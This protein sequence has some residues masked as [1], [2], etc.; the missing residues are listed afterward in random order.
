MWKDD[1]LK[2]GGCLQ[3]K[4]RSRFVKRVNTHEGWRYH[5]WHDHDPISLWRT[6]AWMSQFP[7]SLCRFTR[8]C[9]KMICWRM[10]AVCS[11]SIDLVLSKESTPTKDEGT[12][13]DTTTIQF[14]FDTPPL[15]AWMSRFPR[16]FLDSHVDVERWSAEEWRLSAVKVKISFC[17]KSQHPRRMKV[18]QLTRPRS[19]FTL[20]H[21]RCLRGRQNSPVPS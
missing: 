6:P 18:P 14:H 19:N 16:P 9:G 8:W 21:P 10:E 20:T 17:Q 13:V 5:S 3:R 1:L 15:S 7:P 12:T 2:N 4:Y 11:E